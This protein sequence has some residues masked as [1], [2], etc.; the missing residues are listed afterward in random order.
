MGP[1]GIFDWHVDLP[2]GA[3]ESGSL[4]AMKC[5]VSKET[6]VCL[7]AALVAWIV[8]QVIHGE[9]TAFIAVF[10]AVIFSFMVFDE[11]PPW[12]RHS[13]LRHWLRR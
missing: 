1:R 8:V 2:V 9:E 5:F 12:L 4:K 3:A 10:S 13:P 6:R 7:A 11:P